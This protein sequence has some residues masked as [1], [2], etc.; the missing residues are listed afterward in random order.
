M[1]VK[2]DFDFSGAVS[3]LIKSE[4]EALNAEVDTIADTLK[5]N[6]PVNLKGKY[7]DSTLNLRESVVVEK[8]TSTNRTIKVGYDKQHD[9][10][11]RFVNDG[12]IHQSPQ[13]QVDDTNREILS[14]VIPKIK[15]NIRV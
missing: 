2:S 7:P 9:H 1:K 15:N 14:S 4:V 5:D 10:V 8:A 3:R 11:G 13:N 6:T 12:T